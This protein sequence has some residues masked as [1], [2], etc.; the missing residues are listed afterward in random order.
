MINLTQE[1]LEEIRNTIAFIEGLVLGQSKFT[2]E[3]VFFSSTEKILD[4]L[5][6]AENEEAPCR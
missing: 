5:K 3:E 4:I 1:Q 6:H 2:G